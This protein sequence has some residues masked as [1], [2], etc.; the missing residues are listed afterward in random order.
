MGGI[1]DEIPDTV[2]S[3]NQYISFAN[4]QIER[5]EKE[6][7]KLVKRKVLCVEKLKRIKEGGHG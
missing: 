1:K 6:N 5:N 4:K 2:V 7:V 3:L